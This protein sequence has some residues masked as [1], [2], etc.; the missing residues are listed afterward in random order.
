M[1]LPNSLSQWDQGRRDL[2]GQLGAAPME[3]SY[4]G[5]ILLSTSRITEIKVT[6]RVES[7][8]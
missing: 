1:G 3:L 6:P 2:G 8:G 7:G 5:L 4:V